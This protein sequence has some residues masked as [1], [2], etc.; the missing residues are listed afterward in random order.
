M[1]I[2]HLYHN[3]YE[4]IAQLMAGE[5]I[6]RIRNFTWLVVGIQLAQSV[7]L[8]RIAAM[9]PGGVRLMSWSKRLSRLVDNA[10]LQVVPLY[11]PVARSWLLIA[12]NAAGEVRLIVDGTQIGLGFQLIMLSLAYRRRSLPI[13]WVW[14]RAKRGHSLA[15]IQV[16]LLRRVHAL[17]PAGTAVVL[18]GDSEFGAI[19][20]LQQLDQW[21]WGYVL[22]QTAKHLLQREEQTTWQTFGGLLTHAGQQA[23]LPETPLTARHGY[24]TNLLAYWQVGESRPWLLATNLPNA[25]MALRA[26]RRRMWIEEMFGDL[27]AHGFDLAHTHLRTPERLS[28]LTLAVVLLYLWLMVTGTQVIK[29]GN[30]KWVDRPDR[31]DLSVFQI[32]LRWFKRLYSNG[33]PFSVRFLP[34]PDLKLSGS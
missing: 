27:K 7:H 26:Y 29:N 16:Q 17:V 30:R 32:G 34:T 9:L 8:N 13:A 11:Q 33:I 20:V 21:G 1:S 31:R 25:P 28:R 3:F 24:P 12:A 18:V 6:T 22:R 19:P 15:S 14:V 4:Q 2:N 10:A 5:R 23:W